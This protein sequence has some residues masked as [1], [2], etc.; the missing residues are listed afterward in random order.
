M[1]KTIIIVICGMAVF[2]GGL[3]VVYT[4]LSDKINIVLEEVLSNQ[5]EPVI[6]EVEPI[7]TPV[8]LDDFIVNLADKESKRYVRIGI[9]LEVK[10]SG[11]ADEVQKRLPQVRDAVIVSLSNKLSEDIE[12]AE[13]KELLR[14]TLLT[15]INDILAISKVYNLYFTDFVIQ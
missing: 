9:T 15:K 14:K 3:F 10:S 5:D 12:G 6:K 8:K 1:K 7:G 11:A 13:G 4:L 2:F